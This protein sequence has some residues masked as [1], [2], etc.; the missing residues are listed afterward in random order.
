LGFGTKSCSLSGLPTII[1]ES[2]TGGL[3]KHLRIK[4]SFHWLLFECERY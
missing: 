3:P 4:A 1:L 2:L